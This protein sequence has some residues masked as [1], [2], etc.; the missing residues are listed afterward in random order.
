[1]ANHKP[2]PIYNTLGY[3]H[4]L[5]ATEEIIHL[6]KAGTAQENKAMEEE[7]NEADYIVPAGK[8]LKIL[9]FPRVDDTNAQAKLKYYTSADSG[10]GTLIL[11]NPEFS[12]LAGKVFV[13]DIPAGNYINVA[14]TA[15]TTYDIELTGIEMEA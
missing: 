10:S 9:S 1:M 4:R 8:K 15:T 5:H 7:K 6:Q 13:Y 11:G 3:N 2:T 12:D 14:T